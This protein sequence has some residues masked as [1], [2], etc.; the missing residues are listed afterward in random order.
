MGRSRV[1]WGGVGWVWRGLR[2]EAVHL[3]SQGSDDGRR[4]VGRE[5]G[6]V[7][8]PRPRPHTE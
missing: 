7:R 1:G 6:R 5:P 8:R 3:L 4:G 2:L